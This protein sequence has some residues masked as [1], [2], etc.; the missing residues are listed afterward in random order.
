[1]FFNLNLQLRAHLLLQYYF[2][3]SYIQEF[4]FKFWIHPIIFIFM[5]I[6]LHTLAI[7]GYIHQIATCIVDKNRIWKLSR[8]F[9]YFDS[10]KLNFAVDI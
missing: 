6:N 1:M 4:E 8:L 10:V 7:I 3:T 9:Y 5:C 2:I